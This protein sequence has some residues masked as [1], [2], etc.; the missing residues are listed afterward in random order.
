MIL[1]N[2][3]IVGAQKC[4]TTTLYDILNMHPQA[5]MSKIKEINYF[6]SQKKFKRGLEHYSSFFNKP[7]VIHRITG[8]SSPGYMCYP[9][10][11]ERIKKD[12]G[13][14]KIVIILRDPIKRAFSQ[15]WDNRRHLNENLEEIK[16][17]KL[18]LNENYTPGKKG[19]FSRGV[20]FKYIKQY[21]NIFGKKNLHIIILEDLISN[22]TG[23]LKRLYRF[24]GIDVNLGLQDLPQASNSAMIWENPFYS[25][26]LNNPKY[27]L[28]VPKRLRLF[29]FWGSKKKHKYELPDMLLLNELKSFYRPWNRE[30]ET[31]LDKKLDKWI[32]Q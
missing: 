16:V 26:F 10:V 18:Y 25:F 20:Y 3:L 11:A 30:L 27:N 8:E 32:N 23:E 28:L 7:K 17:V 21:E 22:Q 9:G 1:P 13:Q 2:F 4:G 31:Y 29:L 15:Y 5:N 6:T 14:I 12:L 24:L 19:Y